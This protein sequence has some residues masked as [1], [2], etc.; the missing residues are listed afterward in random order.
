MTDHEGPGTYTNVLMMPISFIHVSCVL[1]TQPG[2][3]VLY[4]LKD[5]RIFVRC[6]CEVPMGVVEGIK[7]AELAGWIEKGWTFICTVQQRVQHELLLKF[8]P[9]RGLGQSTT[10]KTEEP[11]KEDTKVPEHA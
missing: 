6:G 5:G 9:I 11:V 7:A 8:S 4:E 10:T 2:K 3:Q 1:K